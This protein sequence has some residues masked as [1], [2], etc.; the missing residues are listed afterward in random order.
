MTFVKRNGDPIDSKEENTLGEPEPQLSS[1]WT[2]IRCTK[3]HRAEINAMLV[4]KEVQ[5][6][7][8]GRLLAFWKD[9]HGEAVKL[10]GE[11]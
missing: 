9:H 1:E 4:D 6:D 3:G 5:D 7:V 8:L 11:K 2:M 10:E